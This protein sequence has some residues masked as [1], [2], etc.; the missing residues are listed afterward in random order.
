MTCVSFGW[1]GKTVRHAD[2]LL[3]IYLKGIFLTRKCGEVGGKGEIFGDE[4]FFVVRGWGFW[5]IG[6]VG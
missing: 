4:M 1:G 2:F 3:R 5:G 6:D